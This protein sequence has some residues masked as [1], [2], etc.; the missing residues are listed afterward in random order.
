MIEG[1]LFWTALVLMFP[2]AFFLAAL[3]YTCIEG[4]GPDDAA[5]AAVLFSLVVI[6]S[7]LDLVMWVSY[8]IAS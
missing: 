4:N 8:W 7:I 1:I 3:V 6:V 5:A 2:A